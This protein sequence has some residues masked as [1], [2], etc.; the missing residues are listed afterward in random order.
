MMPMHS[1]SQHGTRR[2]T[3]G[4]R[5]TIGV[6]RRGRSRGLALG[7]RAT[8]CLLAVATA[9]ALWACAAGLYLWCHDEL[10]ASLMARQADMQ[11]GYEDQIAALRTELDRQGSRGLIDR[12]TIDTVLH[13]LDARSR[14]LEGR[15]A[16]LDALVA[17]AS[18][19]SGHPQRP[20]LDHA[21]PRAPLTAGRGDGAVA[22]R[23]GA[24]DHA[25][26]TAGSLGA[27]LASV[28][29]RQTAV[30]N[31]LRE[32]LLRQA[33]R[34]TSAL[35][36]TGLLKR[37]GF[38]ATRGAGGPFVALTGADTLGFDDQVALLRDALA[39]CAQLGAIADRVPLRKP[40]NGPLDVSSPFGARL[41][42]FLG[43]PALH[44]GVDLLQ[45]GDDAVRATA[46][47]VI[48]SAGTNG[49][50][51]RMVEIDHGDGVATRYAHLASIDVVPGQ[52]VGPG[53]II[54]RVGSSGRATGPHLHYETRI[55]GVPVDPTRFLSAGAGLAE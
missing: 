9:V 31:A 36:D 39:R 34:V 48:A 32:P 43:R 8:L 18:A 2:R 3:G 49:G 27:R 12:H 10:L 4:F 50:Y 11:Y 19:K 46:A 53:A 44:S 30:A 45:D 33:R 26:A 40:L 35:A 20:P 7:S 25:E 17:E 21:D 6:S 42:P 15:A 29:Q 51:G 22:P 23:P 52:R 47:G 5:L 38:Q 28:A 13:D 41:D 1:T 16:V 37:T 54:G 55:D 14:Q 24:E